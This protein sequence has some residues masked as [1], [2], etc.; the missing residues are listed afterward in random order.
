MQ[1]LGD[2][3]IRRVDWQNVFPVVLLPRAFRYALGFRVILLAFHGLIFTSLLAGF[4]VSTESSIHM[5]LGT[6]R[7][8]ANSPIK[9]VS[10][11]AERLFPSYSGLFAPETSFGWSHAMTS[12]SSPKIANPWTQLTATGLEVYFHRYNST[13]ASLS[14]FIVVLVIWAWLG[15]AIT[16]IVALRFAQDR[17]ESFPQLF[18]FMRKK[19]LSYIGAIILP[20]VGIFFALLPVWLLNWIWQA[21]IPSVWVGDLVHLILVFPF[22]LVTVLMTIGLMLGWPLMFAAISAEG[23]D[24]FDAV[25][26]GF[27]YVYQ[28]PMQF[29]FYHLCNLVI[30]A[31]GVIIAYFVFYQTVTL[32]GYDPAGLMIIFNS[33][34]FAYFWSSQ[35]VIYFLLRRSCDATPNNQVFLGEVKKRTLP[36]FAFGKNGEP[37]LKAEELEVRS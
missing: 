17:R 36:P 15:G 11:G 9:I 2:N 32:I 10:D 8:P 33:F 19:W 13:L 22:A 5:E 16:R 6:D 30:Y 28:R 25:S 18:D 21:M 31:I 1:E 7:Q 4:F 35:T 20:L 12:F 24:A 29:V 26:R 14:W 3:T 37:E 27:S 34:A 23:S